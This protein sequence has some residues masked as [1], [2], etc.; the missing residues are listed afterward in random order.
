MGKM[1][2]S[3]TNDLK[4]AASV[5]EML[6]CSGYSDQA[7]DYYLNRPSIGSLADANQVSELTGTRGGTMRVYL[8]VKQG[9]IVDAKIQVLGC[10]GAVASAMV[11]MEFIKGKAIEQ[12]RRLTDR[13]IFGMLEELPA[14]KQH[15]VRMAAKTGHKA[16]DE[17]RP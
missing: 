12:A 2:D 5:R 15:C 17:Y 1:G 14:Q 11:A 7:I 6:S 8:K 13:D 4:D 16:L 3:A 9:R 10:P